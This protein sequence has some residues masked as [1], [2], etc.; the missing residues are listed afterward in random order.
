MNLPEVWMMSMS[1]CEISQHYRNIC[2]PTWE[3][4]GFKVNHLEAI[5]PKDLHH[6]K[7]HLKFGKKGPT[8]SGSRPYEIDFSP[9]EKAVWYSHFYAWIK[10]MQENRPVIIAEHDAFLT[11]KLEPEIFDEKV[12]FISLNHKMKVHWRDP[13]IEFKEATICGAYYITPD[14][15]KELKEDVEEYIT[16]KNIIANVDGYLHGFIHTKARLSGHIYDPKHDNRSP[17][18]QCMLDASYQ[19]I[20]E[21]IGTTIK[22]LT[23]QE[24]S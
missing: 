22:H 19:F 8:A 7:G 6:F 4:K 17:V 5:T 21:E 12:K 18:Y 10:C 3:E 1:A 13:T 20:D 15:A 24:E 23:L 11:K 16:I 9:T 14:L 2:Q